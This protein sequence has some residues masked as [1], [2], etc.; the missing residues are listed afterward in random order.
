MNVF[1]N[2]QVKVIMHDFINDLGLM[3]LYMIWLAPR[4]NLA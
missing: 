4:M 1:M 2:V 3:I